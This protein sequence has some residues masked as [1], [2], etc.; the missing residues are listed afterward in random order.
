MKYVLL[1]CI[2]TVFPALVQANPLRI[3]TG[4]HA[5]FTRVVIGVP[6]GIDWQLGRAPDGY[7]L[8][9][10]TQDGY[11]L[12]Q[13]FELI[14]RDRI[15]AV[16]QSPERGELRLSVD[17]MCHARATIYQSDYLVIDIRDGPA[18]RISPFELTLPQ[19]APEKPDIEMPQATE[20]SFEISR[21][22]VLPLITPRYGGESPPDVAEQSATESAAEPVQEF[23]GALEQ[24]PVPD[25]DAAL[26]MI[27]QALGESLGRGLSDGLLQEDLPS[28]KGDAARAASDNGM[29]LADNAPLPGLNAR[30]SIDTRAVTGTAPKPQTQIGQICLPDSDFDVASWG[31][32]S[33]PHVQLRKARA[34]L[35]TPTD[36]LEEGAVRKLA[37]LYVYFG[38]G[39]EARQVLDLEGTQS[40][41]RIHLRAIA[42]IIDGE[43][44]AQ[45]L[46]AGQV[47][48]SSQVA[49]WA[50]LAQ[51]QAPVDAQVDRTAVITAYRALP[52]YVQEPIAAR[53]A[54]TLISLG[55]EDEAMQVLG[56]QS[57]A[58][59][60]DVALA[61]ADAALFDALGE[62]SEAVEKVTDLAR[63]DR[64]TNPEAMT[65]FFKEGTA[66]GV[67][68]SDADFLLADALRFELADAPTT[69]QLADAQFDAYLSVD[70]FE[71][72][73]DLLQTR[74]GDVSP[75]DWATY[76]ARLFQKAAQR[77]TDA[78]F[79]EFVWPED[80]AQDDTE[81]Q[82]AVGARLIALRFPAQALVVM[83]ND[84][85]GLLGLQ[86]ESLREQAMRQVL[87]QRPVLDPDLNTEAEVATA[88]SPPPSDVLLAGNPTLRTSRA[89]VESAEQ[90]RETIRALLQTVPAPAD[91]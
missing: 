10:P 30:T 21:N 40:R 12:D 22:P 53:L 77:Q 28:S 18:P 63:N 20:R 34:A 82:N 14:P 45:D 37:Q 7:V 42:R 33:P 57:A 3:Q 13:F 46:F 76:R 78:A 9:L 48:C 35:V 91:F 27:A 54:E 90:S 79:L 70:R 68:F 69:E 29:A 55:A 11:I 4:E 41:D 65:R 72:A 19:S 88:N 67:A 61:L 26:Q 59:G 50:L 84:T 23:D 71:D 24:E 47:S 74:V 64:R 32:D 66:S 80:M 16:S 58:T 52:T 86:Q 62:E 44:V 5:T 38:F 1:L 85:A 56:R 15:T 31:D 87:E 39:H 83:T 81:T 25:N 36:Q 73:R 6:R 43:P 75:D 89:L 51:P 60:E 8:R 17:C 49:L 2:L